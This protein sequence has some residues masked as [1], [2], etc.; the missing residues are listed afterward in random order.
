MR[1]SKLAKTLSIAVI[2]SMFLS[3]GLLASDSAEKVQKPKPKRTLNGNMTLK[4]NKQPAEVDNFFEMFEDG[5]VYGRLRMNTF[6]WDWDK[7][8]YP[9]KGSSGTRDN[10]A[11]G[12]G[13]SLV[14]KTGKYA[15]GKDETVSNYYNR[16]SGTVGFYTSQNPFWNMSP[17]HVGQLKA[18][19]DT[20][21][22]Q[23][24][25]YTET[26]GMTVLGQAYLEYE[27]KNL[28]NKKEVTSFKIGRQLIETVF[29][30]S[31]DTK[32]IP[33]TFD[34]LVVENKNSMKKTKF[35][36]GYIFQQKLRD[37]L[38]SHD[39]ITFG[40]KDG[41]NWLNQ[42]DSAIHKGLS[43]ANFTKNNKST[44]HDLVLAT[45]T[46]EAVKGLKL[47]ASYYIVPE[48]VSNLTLEGSYKHFVANNWFTQVA[49]RYMYQMDNG[50]GEIGGANLN[51]KV[52]NSNA[53]GYTDPDSLASSLMAFKAVVGTKDKIMKFS[54]G[55]SQIADKAD[56]VA[57]WRGFPTGGYTRAMAQYNWRANTTSY[58]IRADYNF[59][60]ADIIDGLKANIR[61]ASMDFDETKGLYDRSIWHLDII[62]DCSLLDNFQTKVRFATVDS[63]NADESY[64]EYRLEFN[65]LF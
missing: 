30:K 18:G 12:L 54:A 2:G 15:F 62:K 38:S 64:N 35:L 14:Y 48:V 65:Y 37:H 47:D 52:S 29:T 4:Y 50:G 63:N 39:V 33:N 61:Y 31:N 60:K 3:S 9:T 17:E 53:G 22:R 49:G 20:L 27:I 41:Q 19:K 28:E 6:L 8:T 16:L 57:P 59:D 26:Y 56:I 5:M 43:Y 58:M 13:G 42:D 40:T 46:N 24:T 51:G 34:A 55:Y 10:H 1:F 21:S 7:E 45:V 32:M 36:F 25:K 11:V 23:K 44:E